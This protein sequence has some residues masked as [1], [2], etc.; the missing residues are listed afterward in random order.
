MESLDR[1]DF[2]KKSAVTT[3]GVM[4][5]APVMMSHLARSSPNETINV[6]VAG[7]RSRGFTYNGGGHCLN[8]SKIPNVRIVKVCD[9][10]ERLFP[11]VVSGLEKMTGNKVKTEVDFRRL[12]DDKDIDAVSISTPDHWHALQ[13]I[14]ACQA[15]KDVYVEKPVSY[16]VDEGRKMVQAARKYNRVVQV[17]TQS[18]SSPVVHEAVKLVRKG[19]LGEVYMGKA[20][21]YRFRENI[22]HKPDG[23]IPEG[24]HWDLFLG[25]APYRPF[26]E[27]R[28]HYQWHWV[29]DT[30]TT[31]FG[32]NGTHGIDR[33]RLVMDKRVHPEKIHCAGNLYNRRGSDQE[34]PNF[35]LATFEYGDGTILETEVRCL[36]TNDEG[37]EREGSL[38]YGTEGWM[39]LNYSVFRTYLGRKSE[40]GPSMTLKDVKPPVEA[41]E[42]LHFGNW[43]DC[44]RSRRWQDLAAD[45]LEGHMSTAMMHLGN[46]S[47]RTGRKLHFNPSAEKFVN[48]EDADTYLTR[49][50]RPPY[51]VPDVV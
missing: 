31:V 45:I 25:P 46:I 5:S 18:R 17:G 6:A 34:V 16:T 36:D 33:I 44:I 29:W 2:L 21:V 23:P 10:D 27:N 37:G 50:Y 35:Q 48:D 3:A 32:N 15:G 42:R 11:E 40:P 43:I 20:F 51:V 13:T 24:V 1:R 4:A 7:I 22:G 26:N 12:L 19:L 41:L 28:F 47:Y 14:W 8:L 9:V 49:N 39:Y 30:S 38:L